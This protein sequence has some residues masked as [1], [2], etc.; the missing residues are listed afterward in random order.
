[1]IKIIVLKKFNSFVKEG[2]I[3]FVKSG[4]ARNYLFPFGKAILATKDNINKINYNINLN[5]EIE[6]KNFLKLKDL[7][8]KIKKLSPL[9]I[10]S[11]VSSNNKLF[12]SVNVNDIYLKIVSNLL[13]KIKKKYIFLPNGSLK[14]IGNHIIKINLSDKIFFDFVIKIVSFD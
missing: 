11:R 6:N 5:K 4:F 9:V 10:K 2:D 14:K 3:L 8:N 1:M 12:G 7:S 13:F